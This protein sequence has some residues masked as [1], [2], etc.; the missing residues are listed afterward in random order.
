MLTFWLR[1]TLILTGMLLLPLVLM[2]VGA[3]LLPPVQIVPVVT[4]QTSTILL[5][6]VNRRVAAARPVV[7]GTVV[8]AVISPD[9]QQIAFSVSA[10]RRMDIY[11]GNLYERGA[12]RITGQVLGGQS[13]A[14]SPDGRQIAF[15]GMEP[16][17]QRG[18]YIAAIDDTAPVQLI[19]AGNYAT[20]AWSPDG[21]Q[22]AFAITRVHDLSNLFV[23][24]SDCRLRCDREVRQ[25]TSSL[26]TDTAP[27]WSP[28]GSTIVFFSNRSGAY[29]MF[30]LDAAC[31]QPGTVKCTLRIPRQIRLRRLFAPVNMLWSLNGQEIYFRAWDEATNQPGLYAVQSTCPDVP[32]GCQPRL[33]FNLANK[34]GEKI[35]T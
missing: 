20:P 35:T 17:N 8:D 22:L 18:I 5:V 25:L 21:Q 11:V 1:L 3:R 29:Q 32:A 2:R 27:V 26:V 28:D 7:P 12:R 24:A 13:P 9:Q 15:V 31:L 33:I 10:D 30:T 23:V 34:L 4:Y 16:L 6:D 19:K 14:W